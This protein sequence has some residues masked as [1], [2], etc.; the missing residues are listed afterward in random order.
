MAPD[1]KPIISYFNGFL[2]KVHGLDAESYKPGLCL[3]EILVKYF[4]LFFNILVK[5]ILYR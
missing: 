4:L 3:I 5:S 2:N 1:K